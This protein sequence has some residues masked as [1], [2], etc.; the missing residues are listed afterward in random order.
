MNVPKGALA[1]ALALA[2]ASLASP[3]S[4]EVRLSFAA[5]LDYSNGKYGQA[6]NTEIIAVPFGV[7][8]SVDDW[9]FRANSSYLT[10]T[11]PA[12]VTEDGETS[13]STGARQGAE[14]GIGDTTL[15]VERAFRRIGGSPAYVTASAR[16][17]LPSGDETQGLGVGAVDYSLVGEA[18]V[19]TDEGGVYVSAGYRFL[20]QTDDGPER[21]D[22]MQ[23]AIGA[24]APLTNRVRV[25]AF[26][27]WREASIEGG[28]NPASA[29]AYISYRMS[30]RLRVTFTASAGL[31]DASADETA[32]I[33]FNWLP[34]ALND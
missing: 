15:S 29:G 31:S 34:G 13:Q 24:W 11:G 5:G 3:A 30:E 2:A 1:L 20:G 7:R 6:E 19:S 33:R 23:G 4:A 18:G 22:G 32:G 10:V 12:D 16:A 14:R 8:L 28:E 21:Q 17:R 26:G 25:G 9:T 27:S